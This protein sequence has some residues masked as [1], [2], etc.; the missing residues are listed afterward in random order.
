VLPPE[1]ARGDPDDDEGHQR[2]DGDRD[3][4]RRPNPSTSDEDGQ[5]RAD[6]GGRLE[7]M[8]RKNTAT[9]RY[10]AAVGENPLQRSRSRRFLVGSS[11]ARF[12]TS[13]ESR[14]SPASTNA[15]KKASWV[16]DAGDD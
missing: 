3:E 16:A 15:S 7:A 14:H 9:E 1:R 11:S 13:G 2:H 8:M 5:R 6:R 4:Q 12:P 10:A